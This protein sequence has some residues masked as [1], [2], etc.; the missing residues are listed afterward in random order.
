MDKL[1]LIKNTA[2]LVVSFSVGT[3]IGNV[4]KATTPAEISKYQ[5]GMIW[6]GSFVLGGMVGELAAKH[7]SKQIDQIAEGVAKVKKEID[8]QKKA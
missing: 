4:I 2:E 8:D 6:I 3:V 5:K 1:E 7:T